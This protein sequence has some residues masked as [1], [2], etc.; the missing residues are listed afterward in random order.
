MLT[1]H[2]NSDA[3]LPDL[4]TALRV[5]FLP[6]LTVAPFGYPNTTDAFLVRLI[7]MSGVSL[8]LFLN[9]KTTKTMSFRLFKAMGFVNALIS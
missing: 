4:P 1:Q 2:I 7:G 6:S 8:I 5:S 9:R 3:Y